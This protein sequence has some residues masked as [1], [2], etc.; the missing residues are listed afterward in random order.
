MLDVTLTQSRSISGVFAGN[1]VEAHAAGVQFL[2]ETSLEP[3]PTLADLVI[4]SAA[5]YPLDL[6]FYQTIK[7]ITAASH[8]VKPGDR[9]LVVGEC[10]EG[11]LARRSSRA[12]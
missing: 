3:L 11:G 10:F 5:G 1:A 9:I 4:T 2:K 12:S 8:I 6:T 7:G